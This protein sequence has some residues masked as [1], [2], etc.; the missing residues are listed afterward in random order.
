MCTDLET[1]LAKIR[2][3]SEQDILTEKWSELSTYNLG[4]Y[5]KLI[6]RISDT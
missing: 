1:S 3:Q 6:F 5:D 2:S 4:K